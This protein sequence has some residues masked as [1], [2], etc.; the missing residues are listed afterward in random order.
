MAKPFP[1][2]KGLIFF[3]SETAQK[4]R[5]Q[6]PPPQVATSASSN[7]DS[8][9]G[10]ITLTYTN[11]WEITSR[12][13]QVYAEHLKLAKIFRVLRILGI[14]I[15]DRDSDTARE[16]IAAVAKRFSELAK[17]LVNAEPPDEIRD[18]PRLRPLG[19]QNGLWAVSRAT[20]IA[21]AQN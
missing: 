11:A 20:N 6:P 18:T 10:E 2:K 8:R 17:G 19:S 14:G 7:S 5:S 21:A 15:P 1:V 9:F 3:A 12:I 16:S 13:T 4:T